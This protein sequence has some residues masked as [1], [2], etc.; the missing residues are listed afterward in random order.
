MYGKDLSEG[1]FFEGVINNLYA[2]FRFYTD[3]DNTRTSIKKA[4]KSEKIKIN[5][6]K[7][8]IYKRYGKITKFMDLYNEKVDRKLIMQVNLLFDFEKLSNMSIFEDVKFGE[9][10]IDNIL[11]LYIIGNEDTDDSENVMKSLITHMN[12]LY[13]IKSY[14]LVKKYYFDNNKETMY[15]ELENVE[16]KSNKTKE[17]LLIA[18][19]DIDRLQKSLEL[20][21]KENLRLKQELENEKKNK[22]E[23]LGL[24]EFIFNL[25]K[26]KEYVPKEIDFNKLKECHS[27]VVGGHDKWQQR[28]NELLPNFRFV[29]SDNLS[30]D[31]KIFD[32]INI[33]FIYVNYLNHSTYYK[34]MSAIEGKDIRVF[35]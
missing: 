23:L 4:T 1:E 22:E 19:N 2:R 13:L 21:E 26:Q 18:N 30:F 11:Y 17:Q 7:T 35:I 12:L 8:A 29:K 16:R 10:D 33:I 5:N 28:M 15:V 32:S 20:L 31:T 24:R 14:N 3:L 25:D 6:L 9:R 34:V 27:I